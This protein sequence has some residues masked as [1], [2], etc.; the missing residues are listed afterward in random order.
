MMA[1]LY[2]WH[3]L[4]FHHHILG[5]SQNDNGP[6][7]ALGQYCEL[8][9]LDP[10]QALPL[11]HAVAF[12][13]LNSAGITWKAGTE[14]GHVIQESVL[15]SIRRSLN[16]ILIAGG[17]LGNIPGSRI[18]LADSVKEVLNQILE[19]LN[20]NVGNLVESVEVLPSPREILPEVLS[21][22]GGAV[23][24]RLEAIQECFVTNGEW[25]AYGFDLLRDRR[26]YS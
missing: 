21:W 20:V 22:K 18:F 9:G 5:D 24:A 19:R 2:L 10:R 4:P 3:P 13:V 14:E 25:K 7:T 8:A 17:A 15:A 23:A 16:S 1:P 26:L 11:A 6:N 12:S